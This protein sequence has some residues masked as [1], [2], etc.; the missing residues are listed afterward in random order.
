M[1][2]MRSV[3]F[4]RMGKT[5]LKD[6]NW[7]VKKD[8]NWVLFGKNGSGKTLLLS[9]ITGYIYPTYGEILRFSKMH[10]N[11]DLREIRKSIGYVSTPLRGMI[12]SF[13]S[14]SI[15]DVVL[16]GYFA[17]IGLYQSFTS[18]M[19]KAALELIE[20]IGLLN[21][22]NE[23]F[24]VLS[25]G[26]K[27]KVLIM[28]AVINKPKILVLDEPAM[29]LDI[30]SRENLLILIEGLAVNDKLSIIYTTHHTEEIIDIFKNILIV[31]EG[32]VFFRGG[33]KSGIT[34]ENVSVLFKMPVEIAQINGRYFTLVGGKN[35]RK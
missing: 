16:T 3:T 9:L 10:Y 14:I 17:T 13:S 1:V 20:K 26:E 30:P 12:D 2:E 21:R 24:R 22:A 32:K 15:L 8:E 31:E 7:K 27:Q 25:D 4:K 6:I 23:P 29:G 35:V 11:Y 18:E 33:I 19:K 28:R 34:S 5:L